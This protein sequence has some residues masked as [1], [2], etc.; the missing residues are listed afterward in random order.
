MVV[1]CKNPN[2]NFRLNANLSRSDSKIST[3]RLDIN[4]SS[5]SVSAPE[6]PTVAMSLK[7][8]VANLKIAY[9]TYQLRL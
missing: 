5:G 4:Q 1:K 7:L 6:M 9:R 2:P 3:Q 8:S